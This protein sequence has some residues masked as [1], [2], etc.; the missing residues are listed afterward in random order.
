MGTQTTALSA[1]LG[2]LCNHHRVI[3]LGGLGVIGH[4]LSRSTKDADIWLDPLASPQL[5]ADALLDAV[6]KFTGLT[7]H[8]LPAWYLVSPED[9]PT[10]IDEVGVVRING[11]SCPLDIFRRP[12]NMEESD[13]ETAFRYSTPDE[14]G[15]FLMSALDLIVTK[16]E[17]GRDRD[18]SDILFLEAKVRRDMSAALLTA[19]PEQADALFDRYIDHAV[20]IA[21]L[22]NPHDTVR[23]RAHSLLQDLAASGD[24]FARDALS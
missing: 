7:I 1:F 8:G 11:L 18:R 6:S 23:A 22:S 5:W 15:T 21:A 17:T 24:P 20:L 12:N 13:F 9:L 19:T 14:D 10:V 3:V 16:E 4:G 2:Q